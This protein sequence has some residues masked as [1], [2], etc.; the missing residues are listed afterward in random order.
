MVFFFLIQDLEEL[1]SK[2]AHLK[3]LSL[4]ACD[5]SDGVCEQI[6]RN[7]NL[8]TLNCCLCTGIS[9]KGLAGILENCTK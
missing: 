3:K 7:R 1:L 4:E 9:A 6:S 2:C 8:E 5:L